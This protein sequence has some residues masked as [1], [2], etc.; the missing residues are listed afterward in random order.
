MEK[1]EFAVTALDLEYKAF[2]VH[3]AALSIDSDDE[4]HPSRKAQIAYLKADEAPIEVLSKYANFIDVFSLKL[5]T[6]LLEHGISNHV[7]ELIDTNNLYTALFIAWN[8]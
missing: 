7:I 5:A 8:L 4:I 6:K 3:V 2:V 1:K